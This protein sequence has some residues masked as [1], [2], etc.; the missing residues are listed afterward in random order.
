MAA[1]ALQR[2]IEAYND[3]IS[4]YNQQVRG[5]RSAA[6]K[7]NANVDAYKASL[8]QDNKGGIGIFTLSPDG[9]YYGVEDARGILITPQKVKNYV[10]VDFGNNYFGLQHKDNVV[11]DPG[12]FTRE[13]PG[14]FTESAPSV[15]TGQAK[16]LDQPSLTDLERAGGG[17]INS[18]FN[19]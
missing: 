16:R 5:Y 14:D 11:P 15:T 4:K 2:E 18:A 3:A 9:G 10:K 1:V 19:Y 8:L 6:T 12:K 7:H 13:Q 17:L